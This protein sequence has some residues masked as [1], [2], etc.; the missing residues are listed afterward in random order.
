MFI[1]DHQFAPGTDTKDTI[2]VLHTDQDRL[3]FSSI[4]RSGIRVL[5]WRRER[6]LLLLHYSCIVMVMLASD[7]HRHRS[8][9]SPTIRLSITQRPLSS[10]R[11]DKQGDGLVYPVPPLPWTVSS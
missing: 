9:L 1:V 11:E 4:P 7:G 10:V 5:R 8:R 6:S 2:R 3:A